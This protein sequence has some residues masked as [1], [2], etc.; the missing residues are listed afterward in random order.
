MTVKDL[1][2]ELQALPEDLHVTCNQK[3]VKPGCVVVETQTGKYVN[4]P[5]EKN[6]NVST[7]PK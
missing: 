4:V 2:Q 7:N 3:F 6:Y 1:I 5:A